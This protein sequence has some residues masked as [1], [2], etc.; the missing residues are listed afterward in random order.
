MSSGH[1]KFEYSNENMAVKKEI[2]HVA[3]YLSRKV[4]DHVQ[5]QGIASIQ[6]QGAFGFDQEN[7]SSEPRSSEA[8][9]IDRSLRTAPRPAKTKPGT[10]KWPNIFQINYFG[11][12]KRDFIKN[13]VS[14]ETSLLIL[15]KQI[16]W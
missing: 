8:A 6:S 13:E 4:L 10:H 11:Q 7:M 12:K 5:T 3:L 2:R 15:K 1:L 16:I 9:T 14:R